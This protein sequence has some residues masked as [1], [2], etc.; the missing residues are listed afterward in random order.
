MTT[1]WYLNSM[2]YKLATRA[3]RNYMVARIYFARRNS[4]MYSPT[5][6]RRK[7]LVGTDDVDHSPS[8]LAFLRPPHA[9]TPFA[10]VLVILVVDLPRKLSLKQ[11]Y[12]SRTWNVSFFFAS[13]HSSFVKFFVSPN[14]HPLVERNVFG[15]DSSF[16]KTFHFLLFLQVTYQC[17]DDAVPL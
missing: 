13:S 9:G 6:Q 14:T 7:E 16:S 8:P 3:K 12:A 15:K 4:P 1:A 2:D 11:S 10:C 17:S 5:I